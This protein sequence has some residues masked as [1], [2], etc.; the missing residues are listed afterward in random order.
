MSEVGSFVKHLKSDLRGF[1][2]NAK[3]RQHLARS[4]ELTIGDLHRLG[5]ALNYDE[6]I[7]LRIDIGRVERDGGSGVSTC[8][9]RRAMFPDDG[10]WELF[11]RQ[12]GATAALLLEEQ[13]RR[14]DQLIGTTV[15]GDPPCDVERLAPGEL[16]PAGVGA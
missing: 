4:H 7:V 12:L 9:I 15:R 16:R 11:R 8:E 13:R 3:H 1:T 2:E 6:R 14:V 10:S 5:C